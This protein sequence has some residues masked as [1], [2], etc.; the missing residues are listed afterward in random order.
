MAG[1][2]RTYYGVERVSVPGPNGTRLPGTVS[3]VAG[4]RVVVALDEPSEKYPVGWTDV[5]E[6]LNPLGESVIIP[7]SIA[8]VLE[9][10]LEFFIDGRDAAAPSF[11]PEQL[12]Y[13]KRTYGEAV[14]EMAEAEASALADPQAAPQP[15]QTRVQDE[16]FAEDEATPE[17]LA[18][19]AAAAARAQGGGLS[20]EQ[21]KN[22]RVPS[23]E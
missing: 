4:G 6:D 10:D 18:A 13:L 21:V 14:Q 5:D 8:Q 19:Q 15:R 16:D 9:S 23:G 3:G 22:A 2:V 20:K 1:A 11:S 12:A 17:E 7:G